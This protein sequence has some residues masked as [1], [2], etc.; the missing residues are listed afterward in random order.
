M[1]IKII[2]VNYKPDEDGLTLEDCG[3]EYGDIVEISGQY[4]KGL[5]SINAIRDTEFVNAGDEVTISKVE[6]EVLEE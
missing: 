5:Y 4:K 3:F 1:K 2:D 6:Y